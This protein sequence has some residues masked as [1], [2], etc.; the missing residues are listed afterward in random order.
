MS[1]PASRKP[2]EYNVQTVSLQWPRLE[3]DSR[4][5]TPV[6]TSCHLFVEEVVPHTS[7][8]SF[9]GSSRVTYSFLSSVFSW[10]LQPWLFSINQGLTSLECTNPLGLVSVWHSRSVMRIRLFPSHQY[11]GIKLRKVC[12]PDSSSR[13]GKASQGFL[14]LS[15]V[16]YLLCSP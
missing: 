3:Q 10:F 1:A 6:P 16:K 13:M 9:F 5:V 8:L 15:S 2:L 4:T 7:C 11:D 14:W 12:D